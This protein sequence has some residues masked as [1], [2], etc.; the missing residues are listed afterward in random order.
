MKLAHVCT[1][2]GSHP[3]PSYPKLREIAYHDYFVD[4]PSP[5]AFG[6]PVKDFSPWLVWWRKALHQGIPP[7]SKNAGWIFK[8]VQYIIR[9][10][11]YV[12]L[13]AIYC[14]MNCC[15]PSFIVKSRGCPI[16]LYATSWHR[17]NQFPTVSNGVLRC[18]TKWFAVPLH[19][20]VK[21][22]IQWAQRI[23]A[24]TN[25]I[26]RCDSSQHVNSLLEIDGKLMLIVFGHNYQASFRLLTFCTR[27]L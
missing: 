7:A 25:L 2:H 18:L 21:Q 5:C 1:P 13:C 19:I 12:Y 8:H 9:R 3:Y 27:P 17:A 24:I 14:S 26:L 10:C 23:S 11:I 15:I 20:M 6:L 4:I 22:L 16:W